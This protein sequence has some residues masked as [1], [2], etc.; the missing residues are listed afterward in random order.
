MAPLIFDN[1]GRMKVSSGKFSKSTSRGGDHLDRCGVNFNPLCY[2]QGKWLSIPK[3]WSRSGKPFGRPFNSTYTHTT[4][5]S[6][7]DKIYYL[8][9]IFTMA[10]PAKLHGLFNYV[11]ELIG[12]WT[13]LV[14]VFS[15]T[16]TVNLWSVIL[17]DL[18]FGK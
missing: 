17:M 13:L 7:I 14:F 4:K 1:N 9:E 11:I 12:Y 16:L 2:P 18:G 6:R 8:H 3:F 5:S 10:A 15:I